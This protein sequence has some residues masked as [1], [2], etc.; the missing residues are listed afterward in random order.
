MTVCD[1]FF[2]VE[3]GEVFP[4]TVLL[5]YMILPA[6]QND[7]RSEISSHECI[8]ILCSFCIF[9]VNSV[10]SMQIGSLLRLAIWEN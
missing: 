4:Y 10:L 9:V 6:S 7:K 8:L 2:G 1:V 5:L 3:R